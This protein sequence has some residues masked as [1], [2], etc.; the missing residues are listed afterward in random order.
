MI[1]PVLKQAAKSF[2]HMPM[3]GAVVGGAVAGAVGGPIIANLANDPLK[4]EIRSIQEERS[5]V[6]SEMYRAERLR[7]TMAIN[8]AR[9]AALNPHLYNEVLAGR[10]LAPG[11]VVFGGEPRT[12][13]MDLLTSRMAQGDYREPQSVDEALS[14]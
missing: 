14:F 8:T 5:V 10:K 3:T 1:G 4:D 11:S 7:R 9:L 12:D 2:R 13:L 6:T